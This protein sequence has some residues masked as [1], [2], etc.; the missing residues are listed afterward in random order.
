[1]P[2][3]MLV[4]VTIALTSI[5]RFSPLAESID[6]GAFSPLSGCWVAEQDNGVSLEYWF[7]PTPDTMIGM[8]QTVRDGA[9]V[10]YE[11]MR[12]SKIESGDIIYAAAPSG[13]SQTEFRLVSFVNGQAVFEN[14]E[15]DFPQFVIYELPEA[16][17]L[18]ARIEGT[19]DDE[20][21]VVDFIKERG[22]CQVDWAES[23]AD[24]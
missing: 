18:K 2:Y 9:N 23:T 10:W 17:V 1:M 3:P 11:F 16:D 13:Q 4:L 21:R 6:V 20:S 7:R 19:I 24:K 22:T 8:S 14:P 12:I 15:H 5:P